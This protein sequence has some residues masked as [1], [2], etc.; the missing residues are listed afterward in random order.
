MKLQNWGIALLT[1][2]LI[3]GSMAATTVM[4]LDLPQLVQESDTIVQGRV[5]QIYSQWDADK[6]VIFT[7]VSINVEDPVKGEQ[8]SVVTIKQLGG[9]IGA[10]NMSIVGMPR[11]VRGDDLLL[12]LKSNGDGTH[13]VVGLGQGKYTV[14]NDVAVS[15]LSGVDLVDRN[16][17]EITS[18]ALI[19]REPLENFKARIRGLMK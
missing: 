3:A 13:H 7:Y 11:F 5:D 2:L 12:F 6:K 8:R 1:V 9:A 19:D 4:K 16:M 17:H 18:G 14:A 15:N 10:M